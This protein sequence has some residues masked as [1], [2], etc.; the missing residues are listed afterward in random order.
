MSLGKMMILLVCVMFLIGCA[1]FLETIGGIKEDPA[2]FQ[3]EAQQNTNALN[4]LYPIGG[5]AV[6]IGYGWSFLRR[7]Y[8]NKK[9]DEAKKLKT[10]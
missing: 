7:W 10:E 4:L 5:A 2:A 1:A 8:A 3:Q 9:R 6:G